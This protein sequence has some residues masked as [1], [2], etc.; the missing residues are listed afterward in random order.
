MLQTLAAQVASNIGKM[1]SITLR[2]HRCI[3][4][5]ADWDEFRI[6]NLFQSPYGGIGASDIRENGFPE[7]ITWRFQSP[8]GGIGA[9]DIKVPRRKNTSEVRVSITLRWQGCIRQSHFKFI[10][11]RLQV[12]ITLR[13]HR[14]FRQE[15]TNVFCIY[16]RFQSPCSG[17]GASDYIEVVLSKSLRSSFNH[18]AVA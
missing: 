11:S 15:M 13:W 14:C 9:S 1:V 7:L 10:F 2:W 4:H 6:W 16:S 18:L 3:R 12:S 17:I 5:S 8:Y